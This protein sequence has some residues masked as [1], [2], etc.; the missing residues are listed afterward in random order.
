MATTLISLEDYLKTTSKPEREYVHGVLK[1]RSM[2][3]WD[4]ASWQE[5]LIAWFHNHKQEWGIRVMPELRVRVA[6]DQVR[7]PD[8]A[9]V[10]RRAPKERFLTHPPLAVFEILSPDDTKPD[11]LEKLEAYEAMGIGAIWVIDPRKQVHRRYSE[12][13][14]QE[15]TVF[16]LPGTG[17]SVPMSEIAAMV[18]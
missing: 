10:S 15:A 14:L 8:V 18:E 6:A 2:P 7:I 3:D 5:A 12:G 1:E 16:E 4:H 17:F 9:L 13:K 11:L